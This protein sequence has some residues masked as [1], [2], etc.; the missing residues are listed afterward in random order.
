MLGNAEKLSI[1]TDIRFPYLKDHPLIALGLG[2]LILRLYEI[3]SL[4][5]PF[6]S[7]KLIAI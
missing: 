3:N 5:D 4:F 6:R 2:N 7:F 1:R